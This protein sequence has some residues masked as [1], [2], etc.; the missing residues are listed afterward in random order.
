MHTQL[1]LGTSLAICIGMLMFG[2]PSDYL[3][4]LF[5]SLSIALLGV[6]HG[7]LDHWLGKRLLYNKLGS[8]WW[9]AFFPVYL[10]VGATFAAGW[11]SLLFRRGILEVKMNERM[12]LATASSA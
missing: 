4:L 7:G 8:L 2:E 12:I 5:T 10:I 11:Y 3:I 9:L 1:Y 6:P